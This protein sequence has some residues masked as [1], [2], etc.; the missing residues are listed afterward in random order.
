MMKRQIKTVK[1]WYRSL[2][3]Q[4]IVGGMFGSAV[5][6]LLFGDESVPMIALGWAGIAIGFLIVHL[7][8]QDLNNGPK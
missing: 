2:L 1:H 3:A 4:T 6:F 5:L 7:R 8:E